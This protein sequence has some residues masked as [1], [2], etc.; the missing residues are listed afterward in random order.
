MN[1]ENNNP[2]KTKN[3][4]TLALSNQMKTPLWKSHVKKNKLQ[5]FKILH[6]VFII[7]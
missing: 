1:P 3:K 4:H 5:F 7:Y 2:N 6:N